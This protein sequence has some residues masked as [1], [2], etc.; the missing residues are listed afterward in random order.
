MKHKLFTTG[1]LTALIVGGCQNGGDKNMGEKP[2][3]TEEDMDLSYT[4]GQNFYMYTNGGWMANNP[5]PDDKSRYGAFDM[6]AEENRERVKGIIEGAAK[7]QA[8]EGTIAQQIGDFFASGM[9]TAAIEAAG[10]KP[11]QPYLDMI[12]NISSK[13]DLVNAIGKLQELQIY[14]LFYFYGSPDSKNSDMMIAEISQ[15]GLGMPDRDYYTDKGEHADKIRA[16]Y[17]NYIRE[18]WMLNGSSEKGAE[19]KADEIFALENKLAEISNTRLQNRDPQATYNKVD[20]AGLKAEYPA[21]EWDN[22]FTAMGV[23]EPKEINVSQPHYLT[24]MSKMLGSEPLNTWKDYLT[25]HFLRNISRYLPKAYVD[26]SFEFYGK[27]LSGMPEQE[28][29]WKRVSGATSG[30]LGEAIGQLFV[31]QYFPPEAKKRMEKLVENLRIAFGER[32]DQLDWMS[33]STKAAAKD[34]LAAIHVKIGYPNKWRD[35]SGL[36]V[37]KDSYVENA[38][39]S[40]ELDFKYTADKI[41]KPVDKDEWHMTPQ[42]VNAYYNPSANE[43]VFPAAILQPPFF[44]LNGDDAVNYGA[45]GVVIGHEMTHGFDDQ[46]RQFDKAGNLNDWWQP[47]DAEKFAKRTKV[48]AERYDSFIVQD[49]IHANGELTMGENIADLGGLNIAFQAFENTL[50]GKAEP[51]AIDGFTAEQRF[52]LSY[53][54]IWAQNIREAEKLR[55]VKTDVHSLGEHRVNGPLP[56]LQAFVNAFNIQEADSMYIPLNMR[57]KIW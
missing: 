2:H 52:F 30:A 39:R 12:Q 35:Y 45:I 4:P 32:I 36:K 37:T 28:P 33:D 29:R 9:D 43:I 17:K 53:A 55:R 22:L 42:T 38:I 14:P 1:I 56:N 26:A 19:Q 57:A 23:A 46:G 16:A 34:K 20:Y 24:E 47:A 41:G 13:D 15:H 3:F 8:K 21:M 44:Y 6:L 27:T 54:R 10:L 18:I 40:N 11:V 51:E 49:T 7:E 50:K 5:L 48:L 25:L 31:A